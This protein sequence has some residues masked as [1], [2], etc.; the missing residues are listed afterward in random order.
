M[1]PLL[2]SQIRDKVAEQIRESIAYISQNFEGEEFYSIALALTEDLSYVMMCFNTE[3]HYRKACDRTDATSDFDKSQLR[4]GQANWEID[5]DSVEA[6]PLR[7]LLRSVDD[8]DDREIF[9]AYRSA[10]G[11]WLLASALRAVAD[12]NGLVIRG[13]R[14]IA[15]CTLTGS[16]DYDV[17]ELETARL[18]NSEA[19]YEV[20]VSESAPYHNSWVVKAKT[21]QS[22]LEKYLRLMA[23][24]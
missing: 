4:W 16:A 14:L 17:A 5:G 21:E 22:H 13:R 7:G 6:G 19:D 11:I 9:R 12:E 2:F 1:T 15:F 24:Q 8:D 23:G 10:M 20:Y 18:L 3:S